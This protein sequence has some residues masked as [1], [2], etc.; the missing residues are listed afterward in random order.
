MKKQYLYHNNVVKKNIREGSFVLDKDSN[1]T[2]KVFVW[3]K[4]TPLVSPV[5]ETLN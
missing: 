3:N 4:M 2:L 5:I 1:Y